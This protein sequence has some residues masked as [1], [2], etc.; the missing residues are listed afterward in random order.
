MVYL[1]GD[2][3]M[4]ADSYH[5]D[6]WLQERYGVEVIQD[7]AMVCMLTDHTARKTLA[8]VHAEADRRAHAAEVAEAYR[9][10]ARALLA[11]ADEVEGKS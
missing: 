5:A 10:E 6:E 2:L 11:K 4:A 7:D 9:A 8:D 1:N 3:Q